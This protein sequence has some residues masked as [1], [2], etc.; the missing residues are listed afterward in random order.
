LGFKE[1]R[2]THIAEVVFT[3]KFQ[4][5]VISDRM[6]NGIIIQELNIPAIRDELNSYI[7]KWIKYLNRMPGDYL[8]LYWK[9]TNK[10]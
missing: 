7:H 8:N 3:E 9:N 6:K 1:E 4:R 2:R 5:Y 10:E